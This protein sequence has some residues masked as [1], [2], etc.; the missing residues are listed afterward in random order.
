MTIVQPR[1]STAP[2]Y[3]EISVP[4]LFDWAENYVRP[5]AKLAFAGQGDYNP[6]ET[7]CKFCRAKEQCKARA[8][9]NL[10]L[11]DDAPDTQ[12]ITPDEAGKILAKAGDIKTWLS[13]LENL[14]MRT[15]FEGS[16]VD[17][18]KLVEGRS[19]RKFVDEL[20]VA[21]ALKT[22]GYDEALLYERSLITLTAMEK[23]FGKKAVGEA[24]DG[25]IFKPQGK[26]TLAQAKDKRTAFSPEQLILDAFDEE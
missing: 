22:A 21:E 4:E 25:L 8:D 14:I 5:R 9:K 2:S 20:K 1:I 12:L 16:D 24:L 15:L 13:D 11:F 3:D 6:G 7:T 26:P 17:G 18:W 10:A 23:A 19:N